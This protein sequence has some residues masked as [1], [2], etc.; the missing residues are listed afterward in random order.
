MNKDE[1]TYFNSK[2][3]K[4]DE[5]KNRMYEKQAQTSLKPNSENLDC[6]CYTGKCGCNPEEK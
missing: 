2:L 1:A 5:N 6:T 3:G 4:N